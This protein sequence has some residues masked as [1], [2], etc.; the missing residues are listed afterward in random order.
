[1][2]ETN[3]L[4]IESKNHIKVI[5]D[6]KINKQD[7]KIAIRVER[8][9]LRKIKDISMGSISYAVCSLAD[10]ALNDVIKNKKHLV[11]KREK[12]GNVSYQLRDYIDSDTNH[13]SITCERSDIS[14][15]LTRTTIWAYENFIQ[16]IK[17][18]TNS[19]YTIAVIGLVKYGID[20]LD[21]KNKTLMITKKEREYEIM[22]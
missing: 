20:L 5:N 17:A 13:I 22:R 11:L 1:M 12:T 7:E 8:S 3:W 4:E 18:N 21:T 10:Y 15:D 16:R 14:T 2:G 9:L 19:Y 6:T